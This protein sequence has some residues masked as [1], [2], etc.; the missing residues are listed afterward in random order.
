[1]LF[2]SV[3]EDECSL[4]SDTKTCTLLASCVTGMI[5]L[6]DMNLKYDVIA[7]ALPRHCATVAVQLQDCVWSLAM[8]HSVLALKHSAVMALLRTA[9][10]SLIV[11]IDYWLQLLLDVWSVPQGWNLKRKFHHS[12]TVIK[13][14]LVVTVRQL[15]V[16]QGEWEPTHCESLPP[17]PGAV[18]TP[19]AWPSSAAIGFGFL[20]AAWSLHTFNKLCHFTVQTWV[21]HRWA[22]DIGMWYYGLKLLLC[23]HLGFSFGVFPKQL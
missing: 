15:P 17:P 4:W 22:W 6:S 16:R 13:A 11:G 19:P 7:A 8:P 2:M 12:C 18:S 21:A 10:R 14:R 3:E 5:M 9:I 23:Q 20:A 1:M